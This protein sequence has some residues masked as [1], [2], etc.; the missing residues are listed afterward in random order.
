MGLADRLRQLGAKPFTPRP[1]LLLLP[2][3][4]KPMHGVN[5]RTVLGKEWWD[6]TRKA[7]YAST[8]YLCAACGT[9]RQRAKEKHWLEGHEVYDID[10][11]LGRMEYVETVPLCHYCHCFIHCGRLEALSLRGEVTR[12]KYRAVM[13]HGKEVLRRA[14]LKRKAAYSGP[15]AEWDEW[16]LVIDGKEYPPLFKSFEEWSKHYLGDED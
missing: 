9:S 11:L 8:G 1:E 16:R 7:A 12:R 6:R 14:K 3:V 15:V 13:K 5:P 10:Y 2:N 4:P